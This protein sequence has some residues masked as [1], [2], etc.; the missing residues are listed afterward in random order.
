[1]RGLQS[2]GRLRKVTLLAGQNNS[3][4]SNILRFVASLLAKHVP[5]FEW[6]DEPQP[7]GPPLRLQ[8]AHRPVDVEALQ[9]MAPGLG[10]PDR[11]VS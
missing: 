6:V 10:Q 1:L 4:K 5:A 2:L 11:L 3:G 8:M 7:Q 9:Q